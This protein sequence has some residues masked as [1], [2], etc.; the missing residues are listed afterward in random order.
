MKMSDEGK[1][2]PKFVIIESQANLRNNVNVGLTDTKALEKA[3]GKPGVPARNTDNTPPAASGFTKKELGRLRIIH[4]GMKNPEVLNAFRSLR[5]SL[6][7]QMDKPN[8]I[9]LVSA[10][11]GGQHGSFTATN[12]ATA[13]TFE[14]ERQALLV[15]CNFHEP[16]LDKSLQISAEAGIL[17][18]LTGR[19]NEVESLVYPTGIP[20]LSVV[21][22]GSIPEEDGS[23]LELVTSPRLKE[24]LEQARNGND[25]RTIVLVAP[26]VLDSADTRVLAELSDLVVVAVPYKGATPSRVSKTIEEFGG[27]EKISGFVMVN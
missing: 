20:R 12:L 2:S 21:P 26:P 3:T 9:V 4:P 7:K 23:F 15:D 1:R 11:N 8:S 17:D 10:V 13:F 25:S 24:F 19:E 27:R 5:L 16:V 22:C 6:L 14:Q 18:Y